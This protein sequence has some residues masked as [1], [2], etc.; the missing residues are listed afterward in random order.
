MDIVKKL[1]QKEGNANIPQIRVRSDVC[2]GGDLKTCKFN[3]NK[4]RERYYHWLDEAQ[5]KGKI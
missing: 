1:K 4:W 2:S 3:L 5:K